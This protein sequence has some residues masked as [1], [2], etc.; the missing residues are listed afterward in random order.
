MTQKSDEPTQNLRI[1][2]GN[3]EIVFQVNEDGLAVEK[4]Y[5]SSMGQV[6]QII[7]NLDSEAR[8]KLTQFLMF[9]SNTPKI[10]KVSRLAKDV[11]ESCRDAEAK[12]KKCF[13]HRVVV[14]PTHQMYLINYLHVY[15]YEHVSAE[16]D[17]HGGTWLTIWLK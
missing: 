7:L 15:G 2:Q 10:N 3:A 5:L 13:Q 16:N 11:L 4:H 17:V 8:A 14:S 6:E 1:E 12:K 9:F